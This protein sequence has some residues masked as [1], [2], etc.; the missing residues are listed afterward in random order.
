M[1]SHALAKPNDPAASTEPGGVSKV[2]TG[3]GPESASEAAS[4]ARGSESRPV[5]VAA[6]LGVSE[7]LNAMP[8][9]RPAVG[10][11]LDCLSRLAT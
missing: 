4:W 7:S 8:L 11:Q 3:C 9:R 10:P 6:R 2:E 1:I 5:V